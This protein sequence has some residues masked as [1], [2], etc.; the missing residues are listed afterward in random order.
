MVRAGP[1]VSPCVDGKRLLIGTAWMGPERPGTK[2]SDYRFFALAHEAR[3]QAVNAFALMRCFRVV[4][5]AQMS[6]AGSVYTSILLNVAAVADDPYRWAVIGAAVLL[7]YVAGM[8]RAVLDEASN[9]LEWHLELDADAAAVARCLEA[10]RPGGIP[11]AEHVVTLFDRA[12]A[13]GPAGLRASALG[14]ASVARSV[15]YVLLAGW[16]AMNVPL[17]ASVLFAFTATSDP[18]LYNLLL[19]LVLG[20]SVFI[21]GGTVLGAA[22]AGPPGSPR[23]GAAACVFGLRVYLGRDAPP[24][25]GSVAVHP[26][27]PGGPA[28]DGAGREGSR[29]GRC[30]ERLGQPGRDGFV[31]KGKF[32][33]A[34]AA[35]DRGQR[36]CRRAEALGHGLVASCERR[37]SLL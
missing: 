36:G 13:H 27:V 19:A 20:A 34:P 31:H 29:C 17:A 9:A 10:G 14:G 15:T 16:A 23:V 3:H 2:L 25:L 22:H 24:C 12:D 4:R 28:S 32:E 35:L 21:A 37:A 30:R 8:L 26:P 33:P 18:D 11:S 6:V 1:D 5:A 7:P